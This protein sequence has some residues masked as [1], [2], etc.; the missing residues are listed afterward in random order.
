LARISILNFC[1][2]GKILIEVV[3]GTWSNTNI[4]VTRSK[5]KAKTT[6]KLYFIP[7]ISRRIRRKD[8]CCPVKLFEINK[9]KTI[10]IA[11]KR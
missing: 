5:T 11:L 10:G 7:E 2:H 9:I 6:S 8:C 3:N 4:G 1:T